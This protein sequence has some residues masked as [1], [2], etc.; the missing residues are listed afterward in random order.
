MDDNVQES[1]D[2]QFYRHVLNTR[3]RSRDEFIAVDYFDQMDADY[4]NPGPE[5][6][7]ISQITGSG[8]HST[9]N[10]EE[11][12]EKKL[13]QRMRT[14]ARIPAYP[15]DD[16][17]DVY[18]ELKELQRRGSISSVSDISVEQDEPLEGFASCGSNCWIDLHL[19]SDDTELTEGE[20]GLHGP[21]PTPKQPYQYPKL[22]NGFIRLLSVHAA[23]AGGSLVCSLLPH[24][25]GE[26]E[27]PL[28][29]DQQSYEALS[30]TWGGQQAT[31]PIDC[32]GKILL[33]TNNLQKAL[34]R[35]RLPDKPRVLWVDAVCINQADLFEKSE[36]IPL[37][38]DI[39]GTAA[40]VIVWLGEAADDS[41]FAISGMKFLDTVG[42]RRGILQKSHDAR[43]LETLLRLYN[44]QVALF[45]RLW[46]RRSWIRQEVIMAK[47]VSVLC[48][49]A[50]VSWYTMKRSAKRLQLLYTTL[51]KSKFSELAS[52]N[53]QLIRP[54]MYLIRGWVFG[55]NVQYQ[56]GDIRSI[57]YYHTG[58]LLDLLM[59]GREFEATDP[60][61]KIY[62]V[63][64]IAR[65]PMKSGGGTYIHPRR[66]PQG[67]SA[68][69]AEPMEIDYSKT[70]SE[71]YQ[72]L[73][74][75]FIN[76]DRNLDILGILSTHRGANSGDLP[77]WTP[78]WRVP[79]TEIEID[80]YSDYFTTKFG[81]AGFTNADEQD[82][83][84]V[85]RLRVQ[86]WPV[87]RITELMTFTADL[88]HIPLVPHVEVRPFNGSQ[89]LRRLRKSEDGRTGII[90]ST[91]QLGDEVYIL[92]GSRL[93]FILRPIPGQ[94]V[95]RDTEGN[96]VD[97]T[98][99]F[100]VIGPCWFAGLMYGKAI[101]AY[102]ER[103]VEP[104]KIVL[105]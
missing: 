78:D 1:L 103:K 83:A 12:A 101:K 61:D 37:M 84:D 80:K 91:A 99:R 6:K 27:V 57:W 96:I 40:G 59:V 66:A 36:Q 60:K 26:S 17:S 89:D 64:G 104:L 74:K 43:C 68:P 7:H 50:E 28:D 79:T 13:Q 88:P 33:I 86:G 48:G 3:V 9:F 69:E 65:V 46:F 73:A 19:E 14:L 70:V 4:D 44:A 22:P 45:S 82:Q 55:Q 71:V 102:Q 8:Y 10:E 2:M 38:M 20:S 67:G 63:L 54:I 85:G 39:Y 23:P 11:L 62:S 18:T 15:S 47:E 94:E 77:T 29:S 97:Y 31:D 5:L 81:A 42:G 100:S 24:C 90:P 34:L 21:D 49:E 75:Y 35:L 58:G 56:S 51:S 93:P 16:P 72:Y 53:S 52:F 25:I 76:R 95:Q 30:Y 87:D 41:S 105:V 98:L 32:D 92:Q